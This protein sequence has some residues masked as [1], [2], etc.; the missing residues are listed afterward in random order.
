M[1][2]NIDVAVAQQTEHLVFTVGGRGEHFA[3]RLFTLPDIAFVQIADFF[4]LALRHAATAGAGRV[5]L[6]SM[7]GKLAKFAAANDSVHS[8]E[9]SQDFAFLA[10]SPVAPGQRR[11]WHSKST[12]RTRPR[13]S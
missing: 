1:V 8:R 4:G 12:V 6:A 13:K 10:T 3:Q 5:T 7:V 9:N 2:Q 11:G